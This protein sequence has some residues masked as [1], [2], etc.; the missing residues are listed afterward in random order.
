MKKDELI[1]KLGGYKIYFESI[2]K[3]KPKQ[4]RNDKCDCGS[5]KKY[6][7]CCMN[8]ELELLSTC[9]GSKAYGNIHEFQDEHYGL[10]GSCKEHTDFEY[11][12]T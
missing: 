7:K 10:C 12:G 11:E 6:K 2:L 4:Q 3:S 8:D 9:C 5:G 1:R